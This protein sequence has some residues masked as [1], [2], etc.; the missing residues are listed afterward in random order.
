MKRR[1]FVAGLG[2]AAW[3]FAAR[4]QQGQRTPLVGV[5][6]AF[7]KGDPTG[8]SWNAAF[9]RGFEALGWS[10]GRNVRIEHRWT[11]STFDQFQQGAR[12][13]VALHPDVIFSPTGAPGV[14]ALTQETRTIPIVFEEVSD[15][16]GLGFVE[17]L[18][19]PGGNVTGFSAYEYSLG[20][21]WLEALKRVAPRVR[22]VAVIF[23]PQTSLPFAVDRKRRDVVSRGNRQG[24]DWQRRRHRDRD[25]Y[26]RARGWRRPDVS[27]GRL[28]VRP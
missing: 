9:M 23:N 6:H 2:A 22:R 3:P 20:S 7:A 27:S 17:S 15:P 4:A 21:K 11:D 19:R 24:T 8:Q 10:E 1:E 16:V 13:L 14:R 5:L 18:A 12:E 26:G 28:H 25:C